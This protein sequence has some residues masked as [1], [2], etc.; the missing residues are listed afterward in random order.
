MTGEAL[1]TDAEQ[2]NGKMPGAAIKVRH[3]EWTE[4][5]ANWWSCEPPVMINGC[6]YEVRLTDL[7]HTRIRRGC[8]DWIFY[9][10]TPDEAKDVW[11]EDFEQRILSALDLTPFLSTQEED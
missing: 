7:G 3:L 11:Q 5:M 1:M 8:E 4:V 9:A 2:N 6:G 10:G